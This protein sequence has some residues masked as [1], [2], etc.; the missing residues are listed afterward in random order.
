MRG[1]RRSPWPAGDD[2]VM[3]GD[4][5]G[6]SKERNLLDAEDPVARNTKRIRRPARA[7]LPVP[8][9]NNLGWTV[10]R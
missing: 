2:R 6:R 3:I 9:V 7:D 1:T 5:C 8:L 4:P 10:D